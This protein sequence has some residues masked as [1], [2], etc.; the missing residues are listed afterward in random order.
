M[1]KIIVSV[2]LFFFL[3][4]TTIQTSKASTSDVDHLKN[5]INQKQFNKLEKLKE[6][7]AL[8]NC[9]LC[10]ISS[11]VFTELIRRQKSSLYE[12]FKKL[13]YFYTF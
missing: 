1:D 6:E 12:L 4:L 10:F 2:G 9:K 11:E 3:N 13:Y 5:L 8:T 7:I